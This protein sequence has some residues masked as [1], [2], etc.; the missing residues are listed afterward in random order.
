MIPRILRTHVS[1]RR[2]RRRAW[3][4]KGRMQASHDETR[5][6]KSLVLFLMALETTGR[7][8]HSKQVRVYYHDIGIYVCRDISHPEA[9]I[10]TYTVGIYREHVG[11]ENT[12]LYESFSLSLTFVTGAYSFPSL[13]TYET[14]TVEML[15]PEDIGKFPV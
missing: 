4:G 10:P 7:G 1:D 15:K 8:L 3:L 11:S 14:R 12:I 2:L 13:H 9:N 6:G 5:L